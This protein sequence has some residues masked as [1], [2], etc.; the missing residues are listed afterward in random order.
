[1]VAE[2]SVFYHHVGL[3]AVNAGLDDGLFDPDMAAGTNNRK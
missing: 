2:G 3:L 1:M